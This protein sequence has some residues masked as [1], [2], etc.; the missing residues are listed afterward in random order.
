MPLDDG[1]EPVGV[2]NSGFDELQNANEIFGPG[3]FKAHGDQMLGGDHPGRDP[4]HFGFD[5]LLEVGKQE[6]GL[7]QPTPR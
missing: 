1:V 2:Q 3:G 7:L 6:Q 5:G 4:F